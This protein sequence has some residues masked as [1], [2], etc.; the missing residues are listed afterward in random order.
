MRDKEARLQNQ[1]IEDLK[2][3]VEARSV[4][5]VDVTALEN[6]SKE[7][8]R[9][10]EEVGGGVRY[11]HAVTGIS[12]DRFSLENHIANRLRLIT[13]FRECVN[14]LRIFIKKGGS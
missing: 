3:D 5:M 14:P 6:K 4:R 8:A 9:Q 11:I 7:L 2:R 13:I 12:L 1:Q 10:L